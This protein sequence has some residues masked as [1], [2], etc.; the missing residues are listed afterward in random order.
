[1]DILDNS[2][3]YLESIDSTNTYL[4]NH[5]RLWKKPYCVVYTTNQTEG[6]GTCERK[7]FSKKNKDLAFSF[8]YTSNSLKKN[9]PLINLS[10]ASAVSN[11]LNKI[12][13]QNVT[14]KEP[15]DILYNNK[16]LCGILSEYVYSNQMNNI[17]IIG[18]GININNTTF[19]KWI[20]NNATSLKLITN[21]E[22][23][24]VS[25]LQEIMLEIYLTL[26]SNS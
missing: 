25:I 7:W 11:A 9:L 5:T 6:R 10:V 24:I 21:K 17:I 12:L 19:P 15:N 20:K 14:I 1:M 3:I 13:P 26:Q 22:Y 18:I 4:K 2:Y 8:V 23:D 16:K